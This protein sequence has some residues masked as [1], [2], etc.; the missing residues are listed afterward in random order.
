MIFVNLLGLKRIRANP[1]RFECKTC[2]TRNEL[3]R[4]ACAECGGYCIGYHESWLQSK[5][6][7]RTPRQ[8]TY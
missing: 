4:Q 8:Q 3:N 2:G 1:A 7:E 5:L 6:D